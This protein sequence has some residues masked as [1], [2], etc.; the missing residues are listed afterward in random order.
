MKKRL[1]LVFDQE[2]CIGCDTCT[3]A[4]NKEHEP[5]EGNWIRVETQ[6][7]KVKDTPQGIF[8]NL[9]M[10][11][12]PRTCMHC[13]NPPCVDVCPLEA[14]AKR[15]DGPVVLNSEL[16][17]GCMICMDECPYDAIVFSRETIKAEK[18]GLCAHRIDEGL[19]PFCVICCEGQAILFG[20]FN[21]PKSEVSKKIGQ[22]AAFQLDLDAGTGPAVYYCPPREKRRL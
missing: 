13:D 5:A 7:V 17:D 16:C 21:N 11:Y 3:V 15:E 22:K 20:D 14:L 12:L 4:C 10:N 18:C 9:T 8:P 1:G 19:E 2:R 6:K